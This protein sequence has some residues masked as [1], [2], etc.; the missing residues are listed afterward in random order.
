MKRSMLF[1]CGV[2]LASGIDVFAQDTQTPRIHGR[3]TPAIESARE[4]IDYEGIEPQIVRPKPMQRVF[5]MESL[6]KVV[7]PGAGIVYV[8]RTGRGVRARLLRTPCCCW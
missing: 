5:R 3:I 1:L 2:L 8:E 7:I 6:L 4:A